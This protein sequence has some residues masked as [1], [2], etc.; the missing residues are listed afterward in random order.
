MRTLGRSRDLD[1]DDQQGHR[2]SEHR[3]ALQSN[4]HV[5]VSGLNTNSGAARASA[6]YSVASISDTDTL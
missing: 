4:Y 2:D 3:V 6:N 5:P 1:L